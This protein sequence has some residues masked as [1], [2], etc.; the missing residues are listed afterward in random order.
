MGRASRSPTCAITHC[1]SLPT[2][3]G[4]SLSILMT[5]D[6][7][8]NLRRAR[9]AVLCVAS[10]LLCAA[11]RADEAGAPRY[12]WTNDFIGA[13]RGNATISLGARFWEHDFRFRN[14]IAR[15]TLE[16]APG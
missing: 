14:L 12:G 15:G 9:T 2:A 16:L 10:L 1:S 8:A 3:T 7:S 13:G 6:L 5:T 11:A 4:S